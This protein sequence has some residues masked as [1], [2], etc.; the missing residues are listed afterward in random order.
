MQNIVDYSERPGTEYP[1]C[2]QVA[3][4][5]LESLVIFDAAAAAAKPREDFAPPV[6]ADSVDSLDIGKLNIG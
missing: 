5:I 1:K 4:A 2:R 3:L 6:I